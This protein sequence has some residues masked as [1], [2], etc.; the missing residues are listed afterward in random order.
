M[1]APHG[2]YRGRAP[3]IGPL[4]HSSALEDSP[5]LMVAGVLAGDSNYLAG[6]SFSLLSHVTDS[7][8]K[9]R[10]AV[11]VSLWPLEMGGVKLPAAWHEEGGDYVILLF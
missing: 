5:V 8:S 11:D 9:W 6:R 1:V 3:Y 10:L 4:L 7:A 2:R